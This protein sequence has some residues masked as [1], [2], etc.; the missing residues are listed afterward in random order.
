MKKLSLLLTIA[1]ALFFTSCV[2]E[3]TN[4]KGFQILY[5]NNIMDGRIPVYF[6][7]TAD[8]QRSI[9]LQCGV[10]WKVE[11]KPA[12]LSI[13]PM[14]ALGSRNVTLT[15]NA[16]NDTEGPFSGEIV[17]RAYNG[18]TFVLQVVQEANNI[19]GGD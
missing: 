9:L 7:S 5:G 15:T 6:N 12:W 19:E 8:N 4:P 13:S 1:A 17:F 2:K 16:E 14:E 10:S 11:S 3:Q 18:Y